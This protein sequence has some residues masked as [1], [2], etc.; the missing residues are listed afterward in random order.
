MVTS[1]QHRPQS[2]VTGRKLS[3]SAGF[4]VVTSE[5]SQITELSDWKDTVSVSWFCCGDLRW[6]QITELSDWKDTVS[7]SWFCCGVLRAVTDHGAE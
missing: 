6:S 5:Q 4:A 2:W 7:V 3:Q 1:E